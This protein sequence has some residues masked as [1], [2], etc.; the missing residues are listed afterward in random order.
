MVQTEENCFFAYCKRAS[1]RS[2]ALL[3]CLLQESELPLSGAYLGKKTGVSRQVVVQDIALLRTEGHSIAATA[4]GYL[5]DRPKQKSRL[6][7]MCHTAEQ[8]TE[9]LTTIIDLG[10]S[11]L[12]HSIAA[13]ARGYLLDRPKQKSRLLKMCHT[14][15]QITEELTTIIDLGGSVLNVMVNHK[16][17]GK[18]KAPLSIKSRRDISRFVQTLTKGRSTPLSAL[19]C[20]YHFHEISAESEEILDEMLSIKSRRDISRFVQTLTKGRSTPLSALTC[21][22]H[23]HEISAESEEILDEIEAALAEKQF[24]AELL[25]YENL[26][27]P[28]KSFYNKSN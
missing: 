14:A 10:G 28:L 9:E 18:V 16:L 21:G 2:P 4:R 1:C 24:L 17:Y 13:T 23:F 3:L 8:I 25:P 27:F 11:V 19:T 15:E 20:G 22:Y 6:L 5:L 12:N 7:K 26:D